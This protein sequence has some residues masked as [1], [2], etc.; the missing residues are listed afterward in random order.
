[1]SSNNLLI[2]IWSCTWFIILEFDCIC[3]FFLFV[4]NHNENIEKS[5]KNKRIKS[6]KKDNST[7]SKRK[8]NWK[9]FI[10]TY[11]LYEK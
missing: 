11:L 5:R 7:L 2:S 1:M 9:L 10:I 3:F 8:L 4:N 6:E